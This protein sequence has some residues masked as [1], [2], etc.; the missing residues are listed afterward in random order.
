MTKTYTTLD[1]LVQR[2]ITDAI[3]GVEENFDLDGF[4]NALR[5]ADLIVW[6]DEAHGFELI[7]DEDGTTPGFWTLLAQFDA[8]ALAE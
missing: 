5:D 6:N 8:E 4:V 3:N 1:E 7:T 2:E